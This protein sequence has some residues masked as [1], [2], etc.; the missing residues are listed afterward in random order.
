LKL[1]SVLL[2]LSLLIACSPA[3]TSAPMPIVRSPTQAPTPTVRLPTL[4][5]APTLTPY[6]SSTHAPTWTPE[7]TATVAVSLSTPDPYRSYSIAALRLRGYGG[8]EVENLGVLGQNDSFVRY[9]IRYPSDG[10]NI[11]GFMNVPLGEGP[12]PVIIAIHGYSNPAEYQT[13]D[14][15]TD[16]ADSLAS[17]GYLV[18]HPNLRNFRPSDSGDVLF[19][20][21]YAIDVLNLIGVVQQTAGQPGLLEQANA[22]RIGLWS[23]SLGSEIALKVAVISQA[24]KAILLYAPMS[25]DER[26]NSQ[27]FNLMTGNSENRQEMLASPE[28]FAVVS[29]N[30]Y[31]KNITAAIQLHHGTGDTVIPIA[32]ALETCQGLKD[33]GLRV[34][35]YYYEGAE[36]TFQFRYLVDF[37]PRVEAFFAKYLK[38]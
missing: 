31:Y 27:F 38:Q 20:A 2:I 22:A 21:G 36:H 1:A 19:R 12:F 34:E 33:A 25:G 17:Q 11:S 35:C 29:P 32:W 28:T 5:P 4:A 15:T 9:S 24:V 6:P 13:L 8:G 16:A 37:S 18:I 30:R 23:H 10:L 3:A 14:Y 7:P 26:K